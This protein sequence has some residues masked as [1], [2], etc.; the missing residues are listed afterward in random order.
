MLNRTKTSLILVLALLV[1]GVAL[2]ERGDDAGRKSKNGSSEGT[3]DGVSVV[4]EYGRPSA[5]GRDIWGG[6]VP[7]GKVWRTG[8]D[9]ATT[10]TFGANVVVEGTAVP[11]GTYALF[12]LPEEKEAAI[13]FNSVADQWGAFDYAA[14]KDVA[15][16]KVPL[17]PCEHVEAFEIAVDAAGVSLSWADRSMSF[18]VAAE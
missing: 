12:T 13:I 4:I 14:D 18:S 8:A 15:T 16:V 9:E 5:N 10:I 1:A 6:L 7:F 2:A 11:A 3:V 17:A